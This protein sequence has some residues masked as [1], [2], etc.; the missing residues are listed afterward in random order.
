MRGLKSASIVLALLA[1][2]PAPAQQ[3]N[4][5]I[6]NIASP[7]FQA[8]G[9][10]ASLENERFTATIKQ[11]SLQDHEWKNLRLDCPNIRIERDAI[12]CDRG[13]LTATQS[14][15]VRFDFAP[16]AKRLVLDLSLPDK[17]HWHVDARWGKRWDFAGEVENGKLA[18]FKAWLPKDMPAPSAG[19]VSGKLRL[20]GSDA[21]LLSADADLQLA[22]MAFSDASGLHAGEKI[23]GKLKLGAHQ[24]KRELVWEGDALWEG[25]EVYWDPF[26]LKGG[27]RLSARGRFDAQRITLEQGTL[28]W[29][30]IGDISASGAWDRAGH[31]LAEGRIDGKQLELGALHSS[32][33]LPWLGKTALAKSSAS[34]K[35]SFAGQFAGGEMT[36]LDLSAD[37]AALQ[38]KEGRFDLHGVHFELPWRT[39]ATT[40]ADLAIEGGRVLA[41]PLGG[42]KTAIRMQD[43]KISIPSLAIPILGG[44]LNIDNF[45]A[46]SSAHGWQWEFEGGLT[47]V[48]ME[49]L[50]AALHWPKMHGTLAGV[51]PRVRFE[52]G[53]LELDGALLIKAFDGTAVIQDLALLDALGPAPRLQASIDMR[54]LDLDLLTSTF[55]FGSMQGKIDV[56]VKG[57]ELSNWKPVAFDAAVR[58]SPGDYPRKISQRAVQNI[59]SLG[60]AGAAAAIQRSFLGIF[61]QFGYSR[62]GLSCVLKNGIC[63]MDGVAAA[64]NGYIIVE[65]GGIPAITV[66]GYNRSVSWD[67]LINRLKRVTQGNAKPV[68]Q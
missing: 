31:T 40:V 14:W 20:S 42:F 52:A 54:N 2:I 51:V 13:T 36:S 19:T 15:P 7:A 48:S 57:L 45:Q 39:H 1:P 10:S 68:V 21:N 55:S 17:E 37:H 58:N 64:P 27:A 62:L 3:F 25:G 32:F 4:L 59:S 35:I 49:Q 24:V 56:S 16:N 30:S 26:Y 28:H 29:P 33:V 43:K 46:A 23:S 41:L 50:S 18:Q 38:D 47:P 60:G 11:L 61:E 6:E 34:G 8:S 63:L 66:I 9:I 67:E 44:T 65:G 22:N 12:A 53:K 5:Q